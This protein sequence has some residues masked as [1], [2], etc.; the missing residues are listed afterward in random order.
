MTQ[1]FFIGQSYFNNDGS[2]FY[3]IFQPIYKTITTFSGLKNTISEW[4]TKGLSNEKF[5]CSYIAN[6]SVCPKLLWTNNSKIR[7]KFK[8]SCLKQENKA[9]F[10]PNNVVKLFIVHELDRWSQDLNTD[11][12]LKDYV[13]GALKLTKNADPDKYK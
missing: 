12:T 6:V 3:L 5:T 11:F 8:G 2:Q 9:P 10:I 13:F 7:L 1:V 4:E